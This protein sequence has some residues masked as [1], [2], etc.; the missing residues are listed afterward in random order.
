MITIWELFL[1]DDARGKQVEEFFCRILASPE[2]LIHLFNPQG[3]ETTPNVLCRILEAPST[4]G[5]RVAAKALELLSRIS[6]AEEIK[7]PEAA[8]LSLLRQ[9]CSSDFKYVKACRSVLC[10][11][12]LLQLGPRRSTM[13]SSSVNNLIPFKSFEQL[14]SIVVQTISFVGMSIPLALEVYRT[15]ISKMSTTLP[16]DK[17]KI[18]KSFEKQWMKSNPGSFKNSNEFFDAMAILLDG[19]ATPHSMMMRAIQTEML[20]HK[21]HHLLLNPPTRLHPVVISRFY[22]GLMSL[23][24]CSPSPKPIYLSD[25]ID[26]GFILRYAWRKIVRTFRLLTDKQ[27]LFE[28][29][30]HQIFFDSLK[31]L[32]MIISRWKINANLSLNLKK[33]AEV[34]MSILDRD[35]KSN[36]EKL[37]LEY[38]SPRSLN[39]SELTDEM[40]SLLQKYHLTVFYSQFSTE[41][42]LSFL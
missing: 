34:Y 12:G 17:K 13:S 35:K 4:L 42:V 37:P 39:I 18:Y 31:N 11:P 40:K 22:L 2:S 23:I 38:S 1:K 19:T 21:Q 20:S 15:L 7:K 32:D 10:Q 26:I 28:V 41:Y 25:I 6:L 33:C 8:I 36:K 24:R 14:N 3:E 5:T 29:E 30:H 27:T 16:K 9:R